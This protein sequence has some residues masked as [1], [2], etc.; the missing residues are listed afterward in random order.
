MGALVVVL[1]LGLVQLTFALW[2]RTVLVDAAGEGARHAALLDS[3]LASGRERALLVATTGLPADVV[4]SVS[5]TIEGETGYDVVVVEITAP[6]PVIGPLG[7]NGT[8][9]VTGRA[10]VE[11]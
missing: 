4:E 11:K 1:V 9:T 2:V 8:M 5:A 7:P 3:D 6:I 10:V